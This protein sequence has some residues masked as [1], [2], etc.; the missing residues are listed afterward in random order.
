M[1]AQ[2]ML[3]EGLKVENVCSLSHLLNQEENMAHSTI[4]TGITKEDTDCKIVI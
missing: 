2:K 1:I 4:F 3:I